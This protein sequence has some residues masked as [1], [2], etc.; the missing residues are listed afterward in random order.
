L[1]EYYQFSLDYLTLARLRSITQLLRYVRWEALSDKALEQNTKLVAEIV[2]RARKADD[3]ISTCLV[4]DIVGQLANHS[5]KIFESLKKV[6]FWKREE[7]K[8]LVRTTFWGSLNFAAEEVQGNPDNIQ[9]KIKRVFADQMKGQPYIPEL[10]K[11]LLDEDFATNGPQLREE[12]LVRL[13]VNK[14]TQEKPKT[15][16]DPR[17]DLM[18]AVRSLSAYSIPLDAGLRKLSENAAL[19][20]V[21]QDSLGERFQKWLRRL[22]GVKNKPRVFVIDLIDPVTGA[23]KQEAL[24]FD[25]FIAESQTRSRSV[26]AV[27]VRTGVAF[28]TL[29]Q[30][31]EDEHHYQRLLNRFHVS[32]C[33]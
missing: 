8:L 17:Q 3:H 33:L 14:V 4:N 16:L 29:A 9:R 12:L 30:K 31:T 10:I 27:S 19:L 11:E 24:E 18:E 25:P 13:R 28:Q 22:M 2:G 6:S 23:T 26:A 15:V 20:D 7:Y 1:A 32:S 21:A 5:A